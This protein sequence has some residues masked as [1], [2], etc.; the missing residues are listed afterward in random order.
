MSTP[1]IAVI[2]GTTRE[3]RFSERLADFV[4]TRVSTPDDLEFDRAM[5]G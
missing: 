1:R 4:M 2:V 5:A 3:G